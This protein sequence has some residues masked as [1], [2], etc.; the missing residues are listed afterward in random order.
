MG[1]IFHQAIF[2]NGYVIFLSVYEFYALDFEPGGMK[3]QPD[4]LVVTLTGLA[5]IS[6]AHQSHECL[7]PTYACLKNRSPRKFIKVIIMTMVILFAF[8]SLVGI[9]GYRTFGKKIASDVMKMYD[10]SD[11]VVIL[12][13]GAL[14]VRTI[15]VYP[16]LFICGRQS[17]IG[18]FEG[19]H[20]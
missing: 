20:G 9:Y 4:N 1:L 3:T 10:P 16:Q 7:V 5:T 17:F 13:V 15:T 19:N 6:L 14:I 2:S 12:G 8:H 18:L 11:V